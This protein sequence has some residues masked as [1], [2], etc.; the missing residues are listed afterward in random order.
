MGFGKTEVFDGYETC[1]GNKPYTKAAKTFFDMPFTVYKNCYKNTAT[2]DTEL[3][4]EACVNQGYVIRLQVQD[5]KDANEGAKPAKAWP[6]RAEKMFVEASFHQADSFF[7]VLPTDSAMIKFWIQGPTNPKGATLA[8]DI[9]YTAECEASHIANQVV[10][11]NM[12][13]QCLS[14]DDMVT[15]RIVTA[16]KILYHAVKCGDMLT[17]AAKTAGTNLDFDTLAGNLASSTY[18]SNKGKEFEYIVPSP[19]QPKIGGGKLK[20]RFD[21]YLATNEPQCWPGDIFPTTI[22]TCTFQLDENPTATR[23]VGQAVFKFT[24]EVLRYVIGGVSSKGE[25]KG[26]KLSQPLAIGPQAPNALSEA[27]AKN[28]ADGEKVLYDVDKVKLLDVITIDA[29]PKCGTISY[30]SDEGKPADKQR[31]LKV[32][33]NVDVKAEKLRYT[34]GD[35]CDKKVNQHFKY[36][37]VAIMEG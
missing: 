14:K 13:V 20:V 16:G 15:L 12:K 4:F 32:G 9:N 34:A 5:D 11:K 17:A 35:N 21:T 19:D 36:R 22:P 25:L 26:Q 18:T 3:D 10:C 1:F 27:I 29:L 33:D 31:T 23:L 7:K 6:I 8:P 28:K 2:S 30:L 37:Y 24:R